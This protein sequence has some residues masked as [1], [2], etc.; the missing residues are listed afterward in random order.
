MLSSDIKRSPLLWLNNKSLCSFI[1]YFSTL[2]EKFC[3]SSWPCKILSLYF[4]SHGKGRRKRAARRMAWSCYCCHC[5]PGIPS[6]GN[7]SKIDVHLGG[8]LREVFLF[9]VLFIIINFKPHLKTT[10]L[11]HE[12]FNASESTL[13]SQKLNTIIG[14]KIL[15][16]KIEIY[17]EKRLKNDKKII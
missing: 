14:C 8:N 5:S 16:S 10:C 13:I 3:I 2:K 1:K 9:Y 11:L 15:T 12:N 7:C 4:L 17:H 6:T